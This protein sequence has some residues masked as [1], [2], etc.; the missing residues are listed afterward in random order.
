MLRHENGQ[1]EGEKFPTKD[2]RLFT[3]LI[4]NHHQDAVAVNY[5][6]CQPTLMRRRH[7]HLGQPG[8][9]ITKKVFDTGVALIVALVKLG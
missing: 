9:D 8:D 1:R 3:L 5:Y 7:L 2:H 4:V 6:I